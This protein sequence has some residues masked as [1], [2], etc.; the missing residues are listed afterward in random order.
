MDYAYDYKPKRKQYRDTNISENTFSKWSKDNM[1][2]TSY[3][4]TFRDV[5]NI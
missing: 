5:K 1:Y 2:R 4:N 3:T